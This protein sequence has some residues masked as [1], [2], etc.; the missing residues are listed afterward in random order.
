MQKFQITNM[1]G[2]IIYINQ[3]GF[4]PIFSLESPLFAA[5]WFSRV[6]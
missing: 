1:E 5:N 6:I 2:K 4:N 3:K